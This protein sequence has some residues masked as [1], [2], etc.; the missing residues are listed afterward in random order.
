MDK[1]IPLNLGD[2]IERQTLEYLIKDGRVED[3]SGTVI[4][5]VPENV[6]VARLENMPGGSFPEKYRISVADATTLDSQ[7]VYI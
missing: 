7:D 3:G 4:N 6:T 1:K 5:A 2:S